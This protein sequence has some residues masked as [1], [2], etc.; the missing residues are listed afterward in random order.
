MFLATFT[1]VRENFRHIFM[2][3]FGGGECDLRLENPELPLDCDIEVHASPRGK[4]TQRIHLLS[5]GERALVA[6]SLLFGIFLTKPSP[7]CLLDE[8]DAPLD[9]ANIGRFVRMLNE[10]KQKTQFIVITHNP[11]TTT[12][13]A[14][15]VWHHH[16]GAGVS[17]VV[18]VRMRGRSSMI[19]VRDMRGRAGGRCD[20]RWNHVQ[21]VGMATSI[22]GRLIP[23]PS[24]TIGTG[25]A[26][27][28][29]KRAQS[30]VL[31]EVGNV[32]LLIDCGSAVVTRMA[33][34]GLPWADITHVA[35]T[36]F[37]ADHTS[38]IATLIYGWRY[39]LLPPR[40][41]P[42]ELIGPPGFRPPPAMKVFGRDSRSPAPHHRHDWPP[43]YPPVGRRRL[44]S[45]KVPHTPESV[46]YSVSSRGRRVVVTGDTGFDPALAVWA[47]GCD[48]L[49]CEC[50]LPD[51]L[52]LPTHLTPRQC[53]TI[54][55]IA[56]PKRLVLT[57]FYPPVETED[58]A[59]QVAEQFGGSVVCCHDG[60][61]LD[62]EES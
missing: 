47:D 30:G 50:S 12:E 36:H 44:Q 35:S 58:I 38:D 26:A 11:R 19:R 1:Q 39:G 40:P 23:Y 8:V 10:F 22:W 59:G 37:H 3:L 17:S 20:R 29:P 34:L 56:R 27:P 52:A 4:R 55:A 14:D 24:T 54:A 48:V 15:A 6:L 46:A 57:H 51:A 13:A 32:R 18:S 62:L 41:A 45:F 25:T 33:E 21:G 16:A 28:H 42:V 53:G 9:D 49:L 43:E 2:T 31:V 60:W 5:S 7:F 61:S